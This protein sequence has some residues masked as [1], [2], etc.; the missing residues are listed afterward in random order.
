[1]ILLPFFPPPVRRM[2]RRVASANWR[3]DKKGWYGTPDQNFGI[4]FWIHKKGVRPP[5]YTR[6]R[7][8]QGATGGR[9]WSLLAVAA[10]LEGRGIPAPRGGT[11]VRCPSGAIVGAGD[12]SPFR[13]R[14]RRRSGLAGARKGA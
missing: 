5:P 6:E 4:Q 12:P 13:R 10:G 2:F 8:T 7:A 1:M 14:K 11:V 9:L 3:I